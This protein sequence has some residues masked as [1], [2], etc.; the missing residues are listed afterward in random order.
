[1]G[2]GGSFLGSAGQ[3]EL[4]ATGPVDEIGRGVTLGQQGGFLG[5]NDGVAGS[6]PQNPRSLDACWKRREQLLGPS[7]ILKVGGQDHHAKDEVKGADQ[8]MPLT[9]LDL[10]AGIVA[11][12]VAGLGALDALAVE[13]GRTGLSVASFDPTHVF[14]QV[15]VNLRPQAVALPQAEVVAETVAQGA[16]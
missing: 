16:K 2:T 7:A 8:E 11:P 9:P 10:L 3:L 4:P 6:P 14:P 5:V 1:V 13:D 15:R 12:L